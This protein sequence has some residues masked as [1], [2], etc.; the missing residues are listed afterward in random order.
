AAGDGGGARA[1]RHAA[2]GAGGRSGA[3]GRGRWSARAG[4]W[5]RG[6]GCAVRG[7]ESVGSVG[8]DRAAAVAGRSGVSEL[9]GRAFACALRRGPVRRLSVVRR[10]GDGGVL[11]VRARVVLHHVRL[12]RDRKSTRLNCSHV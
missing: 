10:A 9:S 6:G 8:R 2:V 12:R 7:G 1:R 5:W 3:G 11:S 4:R